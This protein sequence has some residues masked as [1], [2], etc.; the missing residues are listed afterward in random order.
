MT[1]FLGYN[2]S[3]QSAVITKRSSTIEDI[4]IVLDGSGSIRYCEFKK[5]KE[6]LKHTIKT[7]HNPLI[8]TKYAAVTFSDT[9]TVNFKFLPY[10]SAASEITK[11]AYPSGLTNT[12]AALAEAKKL[13][14]DPYSGILCLCKKCIAHKF[15]RV[16][17]DNTCQLYGKPVEKVTNIR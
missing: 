2:Q 7:L 1:S 6:V 5:G 13:L 15:R 9:A 4:V 14:V 16:L 12:Q 8:D 11:I 3:N 10:L 17:R